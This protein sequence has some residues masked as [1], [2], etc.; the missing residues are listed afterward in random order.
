MAR[1]TFTGYSGERMTNPR[2]EPA[3][4]LNP[5]DEAAPGTPSTGEIA[6][7]KCNGSGSVDERNCE[8]C[9]GSGRV[10]QVIGGA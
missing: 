4:P 8:N 2:T 7:P 9:G 3:P 6:C 10:I 1:D 5:G